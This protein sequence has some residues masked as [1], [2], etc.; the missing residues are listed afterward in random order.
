[1][2]SAILEINNLNAAFNT[3]EGDVYVLGGVNLKLERG[4]I[5]AVVGE[6]GAGKS[7]MARSVMGLMGK[8]EVRYTGE[9]NFHGGNLLKKSDADMNKIRG[10]KISMIFQDPGASLSPLMRVGDQLVEAMANHIKIDRKTIRARTAS[11]FQEVGLSADVARRYPFEL[12]G[13]MQQRVAIAQAMA[14]R[15]EILI[16]DEPTTALDV[17]IQKQVLELL[18]TLQKLHGLSVLFITH[19]FAVVKEIADTVSVMY[20]GEVVESAAAGDALKNPLH[21]YTKA[22][23]DCIPRS[24]VSVLPVIPGFPPRPQ[25]KPAACP[26]A[27]RCP[28]A[29]D[30][31]KTSMPR[32]RILDGGRLVRCFRV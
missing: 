16:A 11:L 29:D 13:G 23:I 18:R 1:M 2:D 31:C 6:S 7:V 24:G 26:F 15:P 10:A 3:P 21:P 12:S 27:P 25:A 20:A 4:T 28:R 14:L 19:N 8:K 32:D 5:H 22:L 30:N 9:I 17:T